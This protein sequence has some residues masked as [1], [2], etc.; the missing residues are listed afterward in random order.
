MATHRP[1]NENQISSGLPGLQ[2][3]ITSHDKSG[4]AVIESSTPAQWTSLFDDTMAFSVLYTTSEMPPSLNDKKDIKT[5]EE[6]MA[7]GK[8][9]L[10]HPNGTVCRI[11]DFGP[12]TEPLMHRTKS[13]DY[14]V[15][16]EGEMELVMEDGVK[17]TMKRGD[18]AIQ[19][20]TIHA[21]KNTSKTEWARMFFVLQDCQ[22]VVV[23]GKELD[24]EMGEAGAESAG[25]ASH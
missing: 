4:K 23:N 8:L 24:E 13:L 17:R 14:G 5:H 25:L 11:V 3:H 9:G 16:L 21:W 7:T 15:V 12:A 1:Q 19:R 2:R 20:A 22:K 18:T 10:A 6:L